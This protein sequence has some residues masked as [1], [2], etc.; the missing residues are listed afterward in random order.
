MVFKADLWYKYLWFRLAQPPRSG[1][2]AGILTLGFAC[3]HDA[4][5]RADFF[6]KEEI[7]ASFAEQNSVAG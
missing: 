2:F 1:L 7:N 3:S 4:C 6:C 5:L